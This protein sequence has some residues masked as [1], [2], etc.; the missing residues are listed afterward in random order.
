MRYL[1]TF[2]T[3]Q[4][5]IKTHRSVEIKITNNKIAYEASQLAMQL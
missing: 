1:Y 5:K 2:S 4:L 3:I